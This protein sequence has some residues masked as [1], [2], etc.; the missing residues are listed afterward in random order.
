M[1]GC[2]MWPAVVRRQGDTFPM[3]ATLYALSTMTLTALA[4]GVTAL[5]IEAVQQAAR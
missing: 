2:A 3:M 1:N 5:L 4:Y